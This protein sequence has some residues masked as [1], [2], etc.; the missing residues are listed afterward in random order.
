MLQRMLYVTG[1]PYNE[2]SFTDHE[3][4]YINREFDPVSFNMNYCIDL[5]KIN[6]KLK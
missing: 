2:L 1:I 6:K 3:P 5:W 4:I